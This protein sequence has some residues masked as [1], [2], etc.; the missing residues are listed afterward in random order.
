MPYDTI[1]VRP[2]TACTVVFE[3]CLSMLIFLLIIDIDDHCGYYSDEL[4]AYS[5]LYV[6]PPGTNMVMDLK[7]SCLS[8][9]TYSITGCGTPC[10]G[11]ISGTSSISICYCLPIALLWTV[12]VVTVL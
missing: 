11:T 7:L 6:L 10:K 8:R 12:R 2:Y 3:S 4:P 1:L 9:V 5:R